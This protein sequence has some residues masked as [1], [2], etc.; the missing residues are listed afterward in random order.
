[1]KKIITSAILATTL[2]TSAFAASTSS[3]PAPGFLT[4]EFDTVLYQAATDTTTT[5]QS[6]II[7]FQI[8]D[9][10]RAGIMQE[11]G[12]TAHTTAAGAVTNSSYTA[13]ALN[14]EYAAYAST[15]DAIIGLN[16]GTLNTAAVG[17][18]AAGAFLMTDI[19]AKT[20]YNASEHAYLDL[21]LGYRMLPIADP[22]AAPTFTSQNA[23]FIKVGLGIKF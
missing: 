19:Y 23:P 17:P 11:N 14:L 3:A 9:K 18:A 5:A 10:L 22:A 20:S 1:M 16:I 13:T 15:V 12:A 4:F 21:K 7:G 8:D 2:A 6:F